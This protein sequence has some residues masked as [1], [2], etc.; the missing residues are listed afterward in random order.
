[1]NGG[2]NVPIS[3]RV[4][5]EDVETIEGVVTLVLVET[6]ITMVAPTA[7]DTFKYPK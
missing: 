2:T 7:V 5:G 3:G 4:I 6:G 1:M